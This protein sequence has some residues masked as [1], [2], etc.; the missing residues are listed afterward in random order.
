M[1][2]VMNILNY[3]YLSKNVQHFLC[4]LLKD[5]VLMFIIWQCCI[6]QFNSG[7]FEGQHFQ[8]RIHGLKDAEKRLVFDFWDKL[9]YDIPQYTD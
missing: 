9:S 4:V 3:D 2:L 1:N 7:F 8:C 6:V 5:T